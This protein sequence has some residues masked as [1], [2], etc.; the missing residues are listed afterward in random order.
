MILEDT[1][2]KLDDNKEYYVLDSLMID[3]N[4]FIII[5]L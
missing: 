2:I 4:N 5:I 3:N 1:I